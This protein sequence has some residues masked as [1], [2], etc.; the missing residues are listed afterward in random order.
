VYA[1]IHTLETTPEQHA[2]GLKLVRDELL[3][4]ARE[5]SGFRG[6][7]GLTDPERGVTLVLTLWADEETLAA[8]APSADELSTLAAE[9]VGV[10]RRGLD[11]YEVTL[12]EVPD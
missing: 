5:S 10:T 6:L 7:V 3:P 1:R 12:Y 9:A 11:S 4:W 8:S 2:Q